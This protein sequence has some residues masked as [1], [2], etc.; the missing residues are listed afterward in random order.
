MNKSWF[1]V[2]LIG[3]FFSCKEQ[4]KVDHEIYDGPEVAMRNIDMLVSDSAI[5]KLRLVARTQLVLSNQDRDFPDGIYLRFYNPFGLVTS[6]LLAD[7]GYYFSEEDYYQAEGN[8]IMRSLFTGDELSTELL[9]WD[10]EKEQIYT[11]NFVT[12]KTEDE[13]LTGEGL[14]ASQNF[15]EY[16]IL[17]PSGVMSIMPQTKQPQTN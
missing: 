12:I 11:D 13:V 5:I 15:E 2:G 17:K 8:V 4:K 7:K 16:T 10:P 9:N 6:T 1:I 3:L 14:E